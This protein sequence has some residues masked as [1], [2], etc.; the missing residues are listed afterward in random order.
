MPHNATFHLTIDAHRRLRGPYTAAGT[1]LRAI[2]PDARD[3]CPDLVRAHEVEI[4]AV[5]PDLCDIRAAARETKTQQ[6]TQPPEPTST[7]LTIPLE[8]TRIYTHMRT[9]SIA[10]G[11]TEFLRDYARI[12]DVPMSLRIDRVDRADPTDREFVAVLLRRLNPAEV[13]VVLGA[14]TDAEVALPAEDSERARL[15]VEGECTSTDLRLWAAYERMPHEQRA[16]L[17]DDRAAELEARDEPSFAQ[18]AIPF[19]RERGTSPDETIAALIQASNFCI[20]MGYYDAAIDFGTRGHAVVQPDTDLSTWWLFTANTATA[21][22]ALERPEEAEEL[23]DEARRRTESAEVHSEAAYATAMLY[24]RHHD[25][26]SKDHDKALA[27]INQSIAFTAHAVDPQQRALH[28]IPQRNA[29][30]LIEHHRGHPREALRLLTEDLT[31]DQPTHQQFRAELH[32]TRAQIYADLGRLPEA[33]NEYRAAIAAL[34]A[35][36]NS[37]DARSNHHLALGNILRR[38]DRNQAAIEQYETAIRLSPPFPELY[39]NRADARIAQGDIDGAIADL[40]YVLELAPEHADASINLANLFAETGRQAEARDV[41]AAAL[42]A[43]PE[44]PQVN[45]LV[46]RL[47]LDDGESRTARERVAHALTTSPELAEAWALRGTL[48][49]NDGDLA[50]A[51]AAFEYSA[52][53][54]PDASVLFNLGAARE[55][56]GRRSEA[57]AAYAEALQLAPENENL[58]NAITR[59]ADA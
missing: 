29:K 32:H 54:C 46:A 16:L 37:P 31:S 39:Y 53:L 35:D 10:H 4:R 21:L 59:C 26:E 57:L 42:L 36:P 23:Y 24:T 50:A 6:Q 18:G 19:H 49:F 17:H 9:L 45:C 8:P 13:S 30:A 22:A 58:R 11:I 14:G 40:C 7:E 12:R 28:T 5:A 55:Q 38:L 48:E 41:A 3:R 47:A 1:L 34:S 56:A 27:W 44:H 15:Y 51:A 20:T 25:D 2:V 52:Q 33:A 43:D